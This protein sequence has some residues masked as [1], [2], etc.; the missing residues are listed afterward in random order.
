MPPACPG[1]PDLPR[2]RRLGEALTAF[3]RL[4]PAEEATAVRSQGPVDWGR[5]GRMGI[6]ERW[7]M[8]APP[9]SPFIR[10]AVRQEA[11]AAATDSGPVH[12]RVQWVP[13]L[14]RNRGNQ[15]GQNPNGSPGSWSPHPHRPLPPPSAPL[16]PP[17]PPAPAPVHHYYLPVYLWVARQ[18]AEVR[19]AHPEP[20]AVVV[21]LNCPQGGG[22]T[23]LC[24]ALRPGP[25]LRRRKKK[26]A[27]SLDPQGSG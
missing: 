16:P 3:L 8:S 2:W 6:C 26:K 27:V 17:P 11:A 5:A 22:K 15:R 9:H 12:C 1:A 25:P 7:H 14:F 13:T 19:A 10:W 23:T 4:D 20:R 24:D 18:V 21:G